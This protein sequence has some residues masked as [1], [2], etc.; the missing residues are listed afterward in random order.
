MMSGTSMDAI[1]AVIVEFRAKPL[2]IIAVSAI[3]S[4]GQTLRHRPDHT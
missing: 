4:H 3:G 1:N 2:R